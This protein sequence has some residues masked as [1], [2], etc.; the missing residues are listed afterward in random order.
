M[1]ELADKIFPNNSNADTSWADVLLG[2]SVDHTKL[3]PVDRSGAEV[4]AHVADKNLVL[5]DLVKWEIVEL[6]ALN[7]FIVTIVE[8][9]GISVNFPLFRL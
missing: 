3:R 1:L 4:R 2:T 7:C 8:I 5:R 6:E 9:R